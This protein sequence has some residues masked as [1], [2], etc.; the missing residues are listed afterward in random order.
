MRC[1]PSMLADASAGIPCSEIALL[2]D[3][4][5]NFYP[6]GFPLLVDVPQVGTQHLTTP[7]KQ[8]AVP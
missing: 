8:S 5:G 7:V 3:T 4:E 2:S 6:E 1:S